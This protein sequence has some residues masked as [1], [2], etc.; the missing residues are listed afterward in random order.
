[1]LNRQLLHKLSNGT[2]FNDLERLQT[3]ISKSRHYLTLN[4]SKTVR[5]T[6]NEILRGTHALLKDVISNDLE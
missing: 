6:D 4:I 2:S 5:D 3:N 1:M